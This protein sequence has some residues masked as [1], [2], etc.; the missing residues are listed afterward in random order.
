MARIY[1][2]TADEDDVAMN[3]VT[4]EIGSNTRIL[5]I[6]GLEFGKLTAWVFWPERVSMGQK[7]E[8]RSEG[9]FE[10]PVALSYAE[11]M[12]DLHGFSHVVIALQDPSMWDANWGTLAPQPGVR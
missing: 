6:A 3:A 7:I 1:R 10:V 4:V 2:W 12:A 11:E 8:A 9:P 5:K